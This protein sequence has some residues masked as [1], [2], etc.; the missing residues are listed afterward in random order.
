MCDLQAPS[1]WHDLPGRICH[2]VVVARPLLSC[3]EG[4]V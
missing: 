4:Y 1:C 2:H 3:S